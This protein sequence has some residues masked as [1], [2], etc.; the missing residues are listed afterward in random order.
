MNEVKCDTFR[1]KGRKINLTD[2]MC[3]VVLDM[4]RID[5][6]QYIKPLLKKAKK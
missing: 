1:S 2:D 6:V 5:Y 3:R 4:T